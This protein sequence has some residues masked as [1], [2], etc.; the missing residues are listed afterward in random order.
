MRQLE[1]CLRQV[2][3]VLMGM[4]KGAIKREDLSLS[5]AGMPDAFGNNQDDQGGD[6]G[7]RDAGVSQEGSMRVGSPLLREGGLIVEMEREAME[8][9]AGG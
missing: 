2:G 7:S 8:A 5:E 1:H 9:G 6:T 3:S 4:I